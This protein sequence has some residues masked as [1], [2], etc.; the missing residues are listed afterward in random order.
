MKG[1]K[2]RAWI[3]DFAQMTEVNAIVFVHRLIPKVE[4]KPYIEDE[5]GDIYFLDEVV[6]VRYTG[7][8]DKHGKEIYE[9]DIVTSSDFGEVLVVRYDNER[10]SYVVT[11]IRSLKSEQDRILGYTL[12]RPGWRRIRKIGN[13]YENPELLSGGDGP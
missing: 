11:P 3:K 1:I 2:L 10:A 6:L 8:K 12:T 9:G 7:L 4:N 13:I 5:Y